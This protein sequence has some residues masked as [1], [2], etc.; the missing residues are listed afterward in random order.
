MEKTPKEIKNG[1]SYVLYDDKNVAYYTGRTNKD[2]YAYVPANK[3]I[4]VGTKDEVTN[5]IDLQNI[6]ISDELLNSL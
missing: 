6:K 4:F 3:N 1:Q 5:F 2:V